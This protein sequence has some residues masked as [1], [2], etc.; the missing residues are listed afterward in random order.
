LQAAQAVVEEAVS[1]QGNGVAATV[2]LGGN[3]EVRR[4]VLSREAED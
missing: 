4:L 3:L 1:P 2:E